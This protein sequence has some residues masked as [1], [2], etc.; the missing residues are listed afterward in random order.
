M[1]TERYNTYLQSQSFPMGAL[2][3]L[4]IIFMAMPISA[5]EEA[6]FKDEEYKAFVETNYETFLQNNVEMFNKLRDLY[7]ETSFIRSLFSAC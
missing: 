1:T 4:F 5:K 7:S 6:Q 3:F 2:F